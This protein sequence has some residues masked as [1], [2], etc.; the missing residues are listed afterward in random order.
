MVTTVAV[1]LLYVFDIEVLFGLAD[2]NPM[3][4]QYAKNLAMKLQG[5]S[6]FSF[7]LWL[8]GFSFI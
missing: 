3:G 6:A 7:W 4:L 2:Y 1:L 5:A 8:G